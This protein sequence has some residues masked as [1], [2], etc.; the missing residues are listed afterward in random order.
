T[1]ESSDQH[2]TLGRARTSPPLRRVPGAKSY[3]LLCVC[4]APSCLGL[5]SAAVH[6]AVRCLVLCCA[7]VT[8]L[9]LLYVLYTEYNTAVQHRHCCT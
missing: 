8:P 7:A 3:A 2:E 6:T 1:V 9:A 4:V 5:C